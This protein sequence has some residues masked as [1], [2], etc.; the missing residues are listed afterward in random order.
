MAQQPFVG[1]VNQKSNT[2][3]VVIKT[4]HKTGTTNP[5]RISTQAEVIIEQKEEV[6]PLVEPQMPERLVIA[7]VPK[8]LHINELME[9]PVVEKPESK[10]KQDRFIDIVYASSQKVSQSKPS[11]NSYNN[12]RGL[13][14]L[15]FNKEN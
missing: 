13:L 6:F 7:S 2:P 14:N 11:E 4:Q 3:V 12:N 15:G 10:P 1:A 9:E 5:P 8:A